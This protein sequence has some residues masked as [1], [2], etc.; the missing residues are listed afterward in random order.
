MIVETKK[1][2]T[3]FAGLRDFESWLLDVMR[4][5]IANLTD[6]SAEFWEAAAGR[7]VDAGASGAANMLR[8]IPKFYMREADWQTPTL[9]RLAEL[10]LLVQAAKNSDLLPE[11]LKNELLVTAGATVQ[12]KKLLEDSTGEYAAVLDTWQVLGEKTGKTVDDALQFRRVWLQGKTSGLNALIAEFDFGGRGYTTAY[13]VGTAWQGELVFYPAYAGL[14]AIVKIKQQPPFATIET[15]IAHET[16]A[17]FQKYLALLTADAP[18]L[19]NAP[20]ILQ[21]VVPFFHEKKCYI[22]DK[23]HTMILLHTNETL[24][25]KLLAT[26]G[27][28]PI[29]LFGEWQHDKLSPLGAQANGAWIAL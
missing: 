8:E 4:E 1:A 27:N 29:T 6:R 11:N 28:K 10:H 21:D 2:A 14:R 7:L 9:R 22:I 12:A 25:W 26:S 24:F 5:G 19:Q 13:T 15:V 17:A 16:F 23:Q 20:C 3:L 18:W